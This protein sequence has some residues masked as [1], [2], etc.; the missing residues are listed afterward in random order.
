MK[1]HAFLVFVSVIFVAVDIVILVV[2]A[3]PSGEGDVPRFWWPVILVGVIAFGLIYWSAFKILQAGSIGRMRNIG[4]RI[5][6]EVSIYE[7]GDESVPE[8]MR[9][10]LFEAV[11]DG[12]RRR[13]DYKVRFSP[14]PDQ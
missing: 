4:S 3:L 1:N 8:D 14:L 6:L 11:R 7:P 9:I 13:V 5:G 12:S 10:P 2:T